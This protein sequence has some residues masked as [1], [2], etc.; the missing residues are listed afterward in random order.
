MTTIETAPV[1]PEIAARENVSLNLLVSTLL[2]Q[3]V[4]GPSTDARSPAARAS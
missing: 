2:A 1:A 3:A 4:T